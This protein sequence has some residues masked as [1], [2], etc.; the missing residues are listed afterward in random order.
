MNTQLNGYP[1]D[2]RV[3]PAQKFE[4]QEAWTGALQSIRKVPDRREGVLFG[5]QQ[6]VAHHE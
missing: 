6:D 3:I 2:L 1:T 4:S 5:A